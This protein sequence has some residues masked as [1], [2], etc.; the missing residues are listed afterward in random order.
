MR[1]KTVDEAGKHAVFNEHFALSN[2]PDV[3]AANQDLVLETYD[4]DGPGQIEFIGG[5]KGIKYQDLITT[6]EQQTL[7]LDL[8]SKNGAK[9]GKIIIKS[10]FF[11]TE[12]VQ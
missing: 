5:T 9:C 2:I 12:P 10:Q 8:L 6:T 7:T 1:T 11:N 3:L 4:E